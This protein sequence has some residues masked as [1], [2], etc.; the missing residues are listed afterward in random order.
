VSDLFTLHR[1]AAHLRL[2]REWLRDE[3][4]AGHLPC[5]RVGRKLLFNLPAV[6]RL[7]AERAASERQEV[8]T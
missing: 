6:E 2:P 4:L 8:R 7:L 3:A 5:L 1:L